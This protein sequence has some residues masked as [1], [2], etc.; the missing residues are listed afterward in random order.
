MFRKVSRVVFILASCLALAAPSV[1]SQ[2]PAA[3]AFKDTTALPEGVKGARVR[4][5]IEVINSGDIDRMK[6][7]LREDCAKEFQEAA[8]L[9]EHISAALAFLRD[10]GGIDFHAVRTYTPEQPD[11]TVVI[12]KDRILGSWWGISFR[13]GDAPRFLIRGLGMNSARPP[14]GLSEPP[15]SERGGREPRSGP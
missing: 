2:Q 12:F 10:T 9:D 13:F 14:V 11:V 5:Y 15:L 6:R 1:F 4:S 7:F 8:P 3:A